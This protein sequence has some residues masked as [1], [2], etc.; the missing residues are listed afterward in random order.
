MPSRTIE[1]SR[2]RDGVGED[3]ELGTRSAMR[4][5]RRAR[6][7]TSLRAAGQSVGSRSRHDSIELA[8][9][10][11]FRGGESP[12]S[13]RTPRAARERAAK[14][15]TPR[16]ERIGDV[17]CSQNDPAPA[18]PNRLCASATVGD[19]GRR[20][21]RRDP[22]G[23]DRLE[24]ASC[25]PWPGRSVLDI[26]HVARYSGSSGR[27]RSQRTAAAA[28]RPCR[29]G[30]PSAGRRMP[31]VVL[32]ESLAF[33]V[34]EFAAQREGFLR[35][36]RLEPFVGF[37]VGRGRRRSRGR[38]ARHRAFSPMDEALDAAVYASQEVL[39]ALQTRSERDR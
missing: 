18:Q 17:G 12:A 7:A 39:V 30:S 10:V 28:R 1:R 35:T 2:S 23:P 3:L 34:R 14:L 38:S 33:G 15:C 36:D 31:L 25:T 22:E 32:Y 5:G 11:A 37:R 9:G 19:R 6:R 16:A 24:T 21:P 26:H 13:A 27:G 8:D 29:R 20:V 4:R